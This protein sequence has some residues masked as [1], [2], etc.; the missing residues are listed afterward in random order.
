MP[1]QLVV[2]LPAVGGDSTFWKPQLDALSTWDTLA[3]DFDRQPD[4]VSM[5]GFADD[6]ASA[7][8]ASDHE[9]A[10]IVGLSMGGVVGL[11]LADA[12]PERVRS[13]TM[14]NSWAWQPEG[15]QRWAWA[16]G[17]LNDKTVAEFSRA[18][19]SDLFAPTTDRDTVEHAIARESLKPH[20][21]YTACW[22]E[23]L[24]ADLRPALPRLRVPTLL[25]GGTLDPVTP[26]DPLLTLIRDTAP[27]ARLVE[28][29]GA[30]HFS[31]L[32]APEAFNAALLEHLRAAS[33]SGHE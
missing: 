6:V 32:D 27:H 22:R 4:A 1:R 20:A 29:D 28:L 30:S 13:L 16:R 17:E 21:F 9:A 25:I 12:R 8:E 5:A 14:A 7:I 19:M 18:T 26:S 10:H 24:H 11:T 2:F 33:G 23:M 15:P 3:L 31:N